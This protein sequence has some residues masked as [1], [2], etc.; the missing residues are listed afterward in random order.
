M[1]E[2]ASQKDVGFLTCAV[3]AQMLSIKYNQ[4]QIAVCG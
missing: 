3:V 4:N 1:M 2:T